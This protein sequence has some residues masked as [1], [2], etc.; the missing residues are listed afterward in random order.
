MTKITI[1]GEEPQ[2][3]ELKPIK[4]ISFIRN[5][6][7]Q[8]AKTKTKPKDFTE[9]KVIAVQ[10]HDFDCICFCTFREGG[11]MYIYTANFN[12]GIV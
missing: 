6:G 11:D 4:L 12:D 9:I 1:I 5:C 7:T 2:K 3:K 8:F 10:S